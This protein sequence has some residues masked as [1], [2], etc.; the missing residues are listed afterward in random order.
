MYNIKIIV[1]F[2]SVMLTILLVGCSTQSMPDEWDPITT[3]V[4]RPAIDGVGSSV[5]T[6]IQP[7]LYVE[8]I[9][10]F[11]KNFPKGSVEYEAL[12]RHEVTHAKRQK[13]YKW[14]TTSWLAQYLTSKKFRWKEEKAGYKEG[15]THLVKN[16]RWQ[17]WRTEAKARTLSGPV[18]ANMVSFEEAKA[19][20]LEIVREA[21]Q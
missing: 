11:W 1:L 14:G 15:I 16:G 8:D 3:L 19:W 21:K 7:Y 10:S 18:Y 17:S 9:K 2:I 6:T 13:G 5:I 12:R 4:E 20:V